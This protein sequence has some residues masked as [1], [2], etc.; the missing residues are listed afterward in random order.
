MM[1]RTALAELPNLMLVMNPYTGC[2][3]KGK[4]HHVIA[5]DNVTSRKLNTDDEQ[6][7]NSS[8]LIC[9]WFCE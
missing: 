3:R 5:K 6:K 7:A 2:G 8:L 9:H 1:E 4:K